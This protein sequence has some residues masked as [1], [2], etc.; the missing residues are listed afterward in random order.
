[1]VYRTCH[2]LYADLMNC[3]CSVVVSNTSTFMFFSERLS[4]ANITNPWAPV[5]ETT[6][7][8]GSNKEPGGKLRDSTNW[9]AITVS[10][11]LPHINT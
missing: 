6:G 7:R 3:K 9:R 2:V 5:E 11:R 8:I 1:M 4:I 10:Q